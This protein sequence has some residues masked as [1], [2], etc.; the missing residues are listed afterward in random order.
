MALLW[1][2][3]RRFKWS[4]VLQDH[5]NPA[6][7]IEPEYTVE[8]DRVYHER[9]TKSTFEPLVPTKYEGDKLPKSIPPILT[10]GKRGKVLP[11]LNVDKSS[12][13][14]P[15]P[16]YMLME[17]QSKKKKRRSKR[18]VGNKD[19]D[20]DDE[21]VFKGSHTPPTQIQKDT[22]KMFEASKQVNED[23]SQKHDVRPEKGYAKVHPT[24]ME[25]K[26]SKEKNYDFSFFSKS[27]PPPHRAMTTM[28]AD[29]K[30]QKVHPLPESGGNTGFE[31][32]MT[33]TPNS[34]AIHMRLSNPNGQ[35]SINNDH[36]N[37]ESEF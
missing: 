8:D 12:P 4:F 14:Y 3:C 11:A 32:N 35:R 36:V 6:L 15:P 28:A 9:H 26:G 31:A 19:R 29:S 30:L 5:H 18:K 17:K 1:H 23:V 7:D 10:T 24:A 25:K 22:A 13:Y 33:S 34:E 16:P 27:H 37:F 21:D 20:Y 2:R